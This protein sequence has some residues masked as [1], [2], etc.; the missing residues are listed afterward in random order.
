MLTG[1]DYHSPPA[2]SKPQQVRRGHHRG[3][4]PLG[5]AAVLQEAPEVR[6]LAQLRDRQL[7]RPGPGIPLPPV[8]V[9]GVHPVRRDLPVGQIRCARGR[10]P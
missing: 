8:P 5:P 9:A 6:P 1:C 3:Q 4:R 2:G 10:S 7:D